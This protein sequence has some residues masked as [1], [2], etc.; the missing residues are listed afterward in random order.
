VDPGSMVDV[1][2]VVKNASEVHGADLQ[3]CF[4]QA[5]ANL[6]LDAVMTGDLADS[7]SV[8]SQS[9]PG[10]V[11]ISMAGI[12]PLSGEEGTLAVLRF[13]VGETAPHGSIYPLLL[14]GAALKGMFG[15]DLSWYNV[16]GRQDGEIHVLNPPEPI[17]EFAVS[18]VSGLVPLTV[19]FTDESVDGGPPISSWLWSFG[20]GET[21]TEQNPLHIYAAPGIY[22]VRLDIQ[23]EL[24]R[25]ASVT[26]LDFILVESPVPAASA[27]TLSVLG[28][29]LGIAGLAGIRRRAPRPAMSQ[30][31]PR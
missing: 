4:T 18:T 3:V 10:F 19:Q 11:R 6:W 14:N 31:P 2:I 9:G 21:S 8:E 23:D 26:M 1:P 27:W 17:A 7:F 25:E 20:D 22:T 29:F 30:V 13:G 24:G 16:V 28:V 15:D 12:E 5:S